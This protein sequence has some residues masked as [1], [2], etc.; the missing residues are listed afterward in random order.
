MLKTKSNTLK[1][2]ANPQQGW[3]GDIELKLN[4]AKQILWDT[5]VLGKQ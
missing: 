3:F 5:F 4:T 2:L 1:K